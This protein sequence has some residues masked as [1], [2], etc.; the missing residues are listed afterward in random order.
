MAAKEKL[1]PE[2]AAKASLLAA[3]MIANAAPKSKSNW[4][5]VIAGMPGG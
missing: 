2:T 3:A 4:P 1:P 5:L